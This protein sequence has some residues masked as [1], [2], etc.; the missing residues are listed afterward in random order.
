V[1][2]L[3]GDIT[4]SLDESLNSLRGISIGGVFPGRGHSGLMERWGSAIQP[5]SPVCTAVN[6]YG[7]RAGGRIG[8]HMLW[9]CS[10]PASLRSISVHDDTWC[11]TMALRASRE[12]RAA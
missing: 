1:I 4:E 5:D 10:P 6:G 3:V 11:D 7:E 2:A 9:G 8:S 12:A